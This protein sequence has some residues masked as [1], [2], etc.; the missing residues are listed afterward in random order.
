VNLVGNAMKFTPDGGSVRVGL[1]HRADTQ[2][3]EI[4]VS[5][6]GI[7]IAPKQ[8]SQL[9]EEFAP[10]HRSRPEDGAGLGLAISRRIVQAHDGSITVS[11]EPGRGS[12]FQVF[13]PARQR[14][15]SIGTAVSA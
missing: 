1:R 3:V 4:S 14:A 2:Q 6:T 8:K 9:F 13:L 15:T 5:D 12:T 11:S 10:I 7:G